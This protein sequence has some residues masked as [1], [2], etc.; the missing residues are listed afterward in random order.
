MKK[1]RRFCISTFTIQSGALVGYGIK[2]GL[3]VVLTI[4]IILSICSFVNM[5]A[6]HKLGID[7]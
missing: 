3:W 5:Y 4:G 6:E 2:Q 1:I 7:K